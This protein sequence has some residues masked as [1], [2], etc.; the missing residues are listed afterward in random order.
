MT[1]DESDWKPIGDAT[2]SIIR[3]LQQQ[4]DH[5][6]QMGKEGGSHQARQ[7]QIRMAGRSYY[8]ASRGS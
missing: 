1:S 2:Q 3:K 5:G 7:A 8:E 4:A 6:R